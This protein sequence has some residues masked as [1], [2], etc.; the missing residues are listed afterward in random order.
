MMYGVLQTIKKATNPAL[1]ASKMAIN[2]AA[3]RAIDSRNRA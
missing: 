2:P 1:M 3:M